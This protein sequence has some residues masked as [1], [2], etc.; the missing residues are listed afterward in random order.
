MPHT[1]LYDKLISSIN[2]LL[3]D[4]K[5]GLLQIRRERKGREEGG[6]EGRKDYTYILTQQICLG[7]DT[8]EKKLTVGHMS[9]VY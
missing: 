5:T 1:H 7:L 9:L 6:K 8:H 4:H 3:A 2:F